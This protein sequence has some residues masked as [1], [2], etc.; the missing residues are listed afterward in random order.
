MADPNGRDIE[1]DILRVLAAHDEGE[2]TTRLEVSQIVQASPKV[3][4]RHL[5]ALYKRGLAC[6]LDRRSRHERW[7]WQLTAEGRRVAEARGHAGRT[8]P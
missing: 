1:G 6:T 3:I 4:D 8:E 7:R 5:D 2:A